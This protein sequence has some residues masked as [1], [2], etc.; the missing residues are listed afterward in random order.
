MGRT[1]VYVNCQNKWKTISCVALA[2]IP[3]VSNPAFKPLLNFNVPFTVEAT[4]SIGQ[5]QEISVSFTLVDSTISPINDHI[6]E[7]IGAPLTLSGQDVY[8]RDND[9]NDFEVNGDNNI[10]RLN[11][12][13]PSAGVLD[14]EGRTV[15]IN[16]GADNNTVFGGSRDD[17]VLIDSAKGTE[18]H[19]FGGDDTVEINLNTVDLN[20]SGEVV[21]LLIDLDEG[22][23]SWAQTFSEGWSPTGVETNGDTLVL[24][25]AGTIDFSNVSSLIKNIETLNVKNSTPQTLNITLEDVFS[26]TDGNDTLVIR[27]DAS[28]QLNIQDTG[29]ND[30]QGVSQTGTVDFDADNN[31]VDETY[32]V[33]EGTDSGGHDV[34][35]LVESSVGVTPI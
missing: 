6:F 10:I 17:T 33:W 1:L 27:G 3:L 26:M 28:D 13:K 31:G 25:G 7:E 15:K 18:I 9:P 12:S 2:N 16:D 19:G 34:T 21:G 4:D 30:I 23:R 35:L 24:S 8:L 5:T 11:E 22:F 14:N 29:N 20:N 32:D